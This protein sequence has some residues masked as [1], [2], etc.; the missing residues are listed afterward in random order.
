[1]GGGPSSAIVALVS[2]VLVED[3]GLG[4]RLGKRVGGI[5]KLGLTFALSLLLERPGLCC[6]V[7][8]SS[9]LTL[10]ISGETSLL[11]NTCG[12][13]GRVTGVNFGRLRGEGCKLLSLMIEACL[14]SSMMAG[15]RFGSAMPSVMLYLAQVTS[16]SFTSCSTFLW[17]CGDGLWE[18]LGRSDV[19]YSPFAEEPKLKASRLDVRTSVGIRTACLLGV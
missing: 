12:F 9:E 5:R 17:L 2:R 19:G 16:K 10:K 14:I 18:E 3:A 15:S 7:W 6:T 4:F 8:R 1:M 13:L 11:T